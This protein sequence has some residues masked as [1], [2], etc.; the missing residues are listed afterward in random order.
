M[1]DPRQG[2]EEVGGREGNLLGAADPASGDLSRGGG[3]PTPSEDDAQTTPAAAARID[4]DRLQGGVPHVD[5]LD[6]GDAGPPQEGLGSGGTHGPGPGG[7]HQGD[8]GGSGVKVGKLRSRGRAVQEGAD[9]PA[10]GGPA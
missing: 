5:A 10:G 1:A 8:D 2:H 9:R 6:I 3:E 7:L 4:P